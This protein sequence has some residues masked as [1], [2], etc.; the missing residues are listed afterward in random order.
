[1]NRAATSPMLALALACLAA[2]AAAQD[3]RAC[4]SE[5]DLLREAFGVD[6]GSGRSM[7]EPGAS[8]DAPLGGEESR[9]ADGLV[10]Q[11]REAGERGDGA[12]CREGLEQ[13]RA[14][15]RE[16]GVGVG[17]GSQRLGDTG[18]LGNDGLP[19]EGGDGD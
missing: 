16:G 4:L 7:R 10:R 15:L 5:V 14:L 17:S 13:A 18:R 1:M 19:S 11:A 3:A 9:E 12:G 6:E 8:E 2:P